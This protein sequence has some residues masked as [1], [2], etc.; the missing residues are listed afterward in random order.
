[1]FADLTFLLLSC[2]LNKQKEKKTIKRKENKKKTP[3][4]P[5][6]GYPE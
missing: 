1:M 3:P 4:H 2:V 6:V 5:F